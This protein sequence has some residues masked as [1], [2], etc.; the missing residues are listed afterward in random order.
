MANKFFFIGKQQ[1]SR[2][3]QSF[4]MTLVTL[5]LGAFR[6]FASCPTYNVYIVHHAYMRPMHPGLVTLLCLLFCNNALNSLCP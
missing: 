3:C 1:S 6:K 4:T 2:C 5:G